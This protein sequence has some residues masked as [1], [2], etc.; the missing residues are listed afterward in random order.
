MKVEAGGALDIEGASVAGPIRASGAKVLRV[1]GANLMASV[2][3]ADSSGPVVIGEGTAG[4]T[5]ND[6][7]APVSVTD[8][9]AGVKVIEN[10]ITAPLTVTGN[11]GGTSVINNSADGRLTV[12]GNGPPVLDKPSTVTG[13]STLQ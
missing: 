12:T 7:T 10:T 9:T 5:G 2:Q 6:I 3:V 4:C 11:T 8:N 1:C 13:K